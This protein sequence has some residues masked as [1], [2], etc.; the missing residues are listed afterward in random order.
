MGLRLVSCNLVLH[1]LLLLSGYRISAREFAEKNLKEVHQIDFHLHPSVSHKDYKEFFFFRDLKV[2]Q[3]MPFHFPVHDSPHFLSREEADSIPFSLKQ[4]PYLLK[5][6]SSQYD[7]CEAEVIEDT[8]RKCEANPNEGESK[9]CATSLES[10]LDFA[11]SFF[12][13]ETNFKAVST[14]HLTK[15]TNIVQNYTVLDVPQE[16]PAPKV[17]SCHFLSYPYAVFGCHSQITENKVFRVLL[18]GDN[19]DTV[20]AIAVCHMDASQWTHNHLSFWVLDIEPGNSPVCHYFPAVNIVFV[21]ASAA[22]D[23]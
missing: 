15:P 13:L 22:I 14:I 11:R 10:M 2:G 3:K 4:L 17:V 7:S 16:I 1:I 8:L 6:F 9:F 20:E 5:Y 18:G 12:G 21:P 23:A 19:G